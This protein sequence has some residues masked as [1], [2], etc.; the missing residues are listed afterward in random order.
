MGGGKKKIMRDA[1]YFRG[2]ET[3]EN[4]NNLTAPIGMHEIAERSSRAPAMAN[5]DIRTV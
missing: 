2:D 4:I 5:K 3:D 1:M